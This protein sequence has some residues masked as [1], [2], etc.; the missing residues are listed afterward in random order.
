MAAVI[1]ERIITVP[2]Q[3]VGRVPVTPEVLVPRLGE[4]L[5]ESGLIDNS[6]LQEALD[7]Q[8]TMAAT[9][10]PILLGQSLIQLS[11]IG[12][13]DLDKVV[14]GQILELQSALKDTNQQLEKRVQERTAELQRA[15]SKLT[16]L[17]QLKTN[18]VSN[19]SHELRT[20]LAH[21]LGYIDLLQDKVLGPLSEEQ[22]EAVR[23]LHKAYSR[24]ESL[25]DNLIQFS[26]ASQGELSLNIKPVS[27]PM[28]LNSVA[29]KSHSKA[30][31]KNI[32]LIA[33]VPNDLP[34]VLADSDK[35][36]WVV[37]QLVDNGIKFNRPGGHVVLRTSIDSS[38]MMLSVIDDGIGIPENNI[39]EIFD[40]FHQLD[41][42][43]TRNHGGTGLGL[44]M[45]KRI[46]EAHGSEL[47][48]ESK[49]G[50]G[51]KFEFSLTLV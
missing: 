23:I 16:E 28:I 27:V 30:M 33:D 5:V 49:L 43:T 42:S 48:V 41:G 8:Q 44:S 35:I 25:I 18:F 34:I 3:Q 11:K 36:A 20:P 4:Y 12:R 15:L 26:M 19:I 51:S 17:N 31:E 39:D 46:V 45:A 37:E 7:Y 2:S 40:E 24:L 29:K 22:Y 14:T 47:T 50:R 6:E 32:K 21:M 13:E 9:G 1:A 38:R 10:E